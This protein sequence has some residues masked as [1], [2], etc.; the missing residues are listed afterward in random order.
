MHDM[1]RPP[2]SS[3]PPQIGVETPRSP[4]VRSLVEV[5]LPPFAALAF[6]FVISLVLRERVTFWFGA[7]RAAFPPPFLRLL[8]TAIATVSQPANQ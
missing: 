2:P 7:V 1:S 6:S 8:P 5:T 3:H 4:T